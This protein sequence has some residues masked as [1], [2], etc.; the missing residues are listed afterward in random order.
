[1]AAC[2]ASGTRTEAASTSGRRA[3]Q[4]LNRN[5]RAPR[6]LRA[7]CSDARDADGQEQGQGDEGALRAFWASRGVRD[8]KKMTAAL[9]W[10]G[11]KG[12]KQYGVHVNTIPIAPVWRESGVSCPSDVNENFLKLKRLL[13]DQI[14]GDD[15]EV[16][17][18]FVLLREPRLLVVPIG[19]L[20]SRMV[21]MASLCIDD[22]V[23]V[24]QVLTKNPSSLLDD[25]GGIDFESDQHG[26]MLALCRRYVG[27]HGDLLVGERLGYDG[28]GLDGDD[29]DA[30]LARWIVLQRK[31]RRKGELEGDEECELESLGIEWSA[32]AADWELH[33]RKLEEYIAS[34]GHAELVPYGATDEGSSL[35]WHWC[36]IQRV[37]NRNG[38][39]SPERKRRL[40][41]LSFDFD[42]VDAA[43]A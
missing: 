18:P 15:V 43:H 11:G 22:G 41:A 39:L 1:M 13:G 4:R 36:S 28:H 21:R 33:Y 19:V 35:L 3:T 20:A 27:A 2:R 7:R 40:D 10:E 12:M 34:F 17:L 14:D 9:K 6:R 23:S 26:N 5:S 16:D 24:A 32:D 31:K 8:E 29:D 38:V 25:D 42:G 30:R 37:A